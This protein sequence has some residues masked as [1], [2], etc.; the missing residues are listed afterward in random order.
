MPAVLFAAVLG[1]GLSY[2]PVEL[3]GPAEAA[4]YVHD[5]GHRRILF[6]GSLSNGAFIFAIRS[7]DPQLSTIV[8]RC[9]KLAEDTFVPEHLNSLV[10]RYG[11]DSVILE[12]TANPQAWDAL[13]AGVLPFL[14]QEKLVSMTDTDHYRDGTLSIYRV[15]DP[16]N[17]PENTLKVPISVL[18][19]DVDLHF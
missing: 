15:K 10:R 16:T 14:S 19:R 5:S 1:Y 7:F 12:R 4:K 18:G 3:H 2:G 6:C 11:I 9:D 17:V 13:G 8:I